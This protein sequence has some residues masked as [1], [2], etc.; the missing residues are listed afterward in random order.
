[1]GMGSIP[2]HMCPHQTHI[3]EG[4]TGDRSQMK[5]GFCAS[6]AA[7]KLST[8]AA[9]SEA[10]P[11]RNPEVPPLKSLQ[12]LCAYKHCTDGSMVAVPAYFHSK[13]K[14]PV[15]SSL[16]KHCVCRTATAPRERYCSTNQNKT[17]KRHP[18]TAATS[19][20]AVHRQE[21]TDQPVRM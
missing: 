21:I 18:P 15:Q 1:M 11:P 12:K 20:C 19:V 3:C 8:L 14:W 17:N 5:G 6:G 9:A 7:F 16:P 4:M 2:P 10:K 13:S